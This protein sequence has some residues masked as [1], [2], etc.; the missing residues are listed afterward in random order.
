VP[1]I[2]KA[3]PDIPYTLNGKKV[4]I[5]IKKI[6]HGM[7]VKNKDALAN[8]ECLDFFEGILDN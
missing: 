5:A 4:E 2:I 8:P 6:I 1:A 3:V 7:E